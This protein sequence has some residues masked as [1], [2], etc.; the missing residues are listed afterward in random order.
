MCLRKTKGR[1]ERRDSTIDEETG[2]VTVKCVGFM[3]IMCE[4]THM[5]RRCRERKEL[6][7]LCVCARV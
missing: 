5:H 6:S 2:R 7:L 4:H 3:I 1:K